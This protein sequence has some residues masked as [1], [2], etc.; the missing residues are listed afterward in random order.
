M[1]WLVLAVLLGGLLA[2]IS[3]GTINLGV[4]KYRNPKPGAN[5]EFDFDKW[6]KAIGE[7]DK[8]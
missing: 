3:T 1:R 6:K 4:G 7:R 8:R 5:Y 2:M